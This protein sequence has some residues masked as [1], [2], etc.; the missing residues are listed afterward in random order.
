MEF[1]VINLD[2]A[3][4][5]SV[6][7]AVFK[8]GKSGDAALLDELFYHTPHT[9]SKDDMLIMLRSAYAQ[10]VGQSQGGKNKAKN[11]NS[12]TK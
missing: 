3:I 4:A 9:A 12:L 11:S 2:R 7:R 1:K 5:K 8:S 6:A 10:I